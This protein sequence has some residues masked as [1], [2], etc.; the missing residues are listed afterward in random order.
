MNRGREIF[1]V[2]Q[3]KISQIPQPQRDVMLREAR[4]MF[5]TSISWV[6][7]QL[8]LKKKRAREE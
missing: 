1:D 7:S 6:D 5:E 3:E 4:T 8:W 2:F